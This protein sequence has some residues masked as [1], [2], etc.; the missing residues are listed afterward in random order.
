MMTFN[1]TK[2]FLITLFL[3]IN[4]TQA[5]IS[6]P[7][8]TKIGPE[9]LSAKITQGTT[10]KLD[11]KSFTLGL[12]Y[13]QVTYKTKDPTSTKKSQITDNGAPSLILE[14]NSKEKILKEWPLLVGSAVIGWDINAAAGVFETRYQLIN[15]AIRGQDGG[16]TVSGSY[17]GVAPTLF[18]KVGPLYPNQDIYWKIGLGAGP[19]LLKSKGRVSIASGNTRI[20]HDVGSSSP[21][22]ALY[23]S[24]LWQLQVG[25]WYFDIMGKWLV[26]QDSNRTTLESYG[27]GFAYRFSF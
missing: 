4:K 21:I 1:F 10:F 27:F 17:I 16:T 12:A 14:L 6:T 8:T 3:I 20:N 23:N 7:E 19:G 9:P 25:Q 5:Q 2:L 13:A 26:A 11:Q 24:G 15:S 22:F 18:L